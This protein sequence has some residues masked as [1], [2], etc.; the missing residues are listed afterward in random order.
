MMK[1]GP[2]CDTPVNHCPYCGYKL[3]SAFGVGNQAKPKPSDVSICGRCGNFLIFDDRL[4]LRKPLEC[5]TR[6]LGRDPLI[7]LARKA[8]LEVATERNRE[9]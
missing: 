7:Q 3:D 5:E 8:A 6:L 4:N 1:T 9:N 2:S